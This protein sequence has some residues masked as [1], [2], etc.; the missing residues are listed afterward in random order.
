MITVLWVMTV[1]SVVATAAA[2]SGR[3]AVNATRNRIEVE[4][5]YWDAAACGARAHEQI[6]RLLHEAS[7]PDEAAMRWR[8]LSNLLEPVSGHDGT[9]CDIRLEAAGTRIDVNV[10]TS[11]VLVRLFRSLGRADR[12]DSLADALIDWRDTDDV[13][14]PFGAERDWYFAASR[15]L[16][17]NGPIAALGEL[18]RVRGFDAT[19]PLD[20]FLSTEPGRVCL[21]TAPASV[22]ASIPG[23]T[24]EAAEQIVALREEGTSL[25]DLPAVIPF[26]SRQS[27]DSL[28]ARYPDASRLTTPDPDAWLLTMRASRGLPPSTATIVVRLARAGTRAIVTSFRSAP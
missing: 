20:S 6:D 15:R 24:E 13:A 17:R 26:I 28:M 22:L 9:P 23:I 3:D 27:A 7:T 1:A 8:R 4:R 5:A 18:A 11:E 10:A 12:A 19:P 16:P 21:A 14:Q 25:A 2:L